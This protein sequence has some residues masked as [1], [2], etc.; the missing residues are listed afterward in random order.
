M[1]FKNKIAVIFGGSGAIGSAVA[2]ALARE[3]AEVHLAA[4]TSTRLEHVANS[5]RNAG[6][7]ASAFIFDALDEFAQL[8]EFAHIDIVVN[9]TG[10]MHDQGKRLDALALSE[11]RQGFDPF[12]T[13][14]F[15]I[16]KAVSPRMGGEHGGTLIT[17]VAPAVNMAISGH[18][19]HIVGCAGTEA[20]TRA[21]AAELGVKNIRVV[22]VRS[23]AIADAVQAG[24][25]VGAIFAAKAQEMGITVEQ[26][27]GGAAQSTLTHHLPTLAQVADTI[28]FLAS[29]AASAIT[30]TTVNMTAGAT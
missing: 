5:I 29:D 25:Y 7:S 10:F 19:G 6:G 2:H 22:C 9:A 3:G 1:G 28:T 17:V 24:S 4:R 23:H 8:P 13:A 27:L 18:L 16:A 21:L 30:G 11:F 14:Y 12:L 15:N 26:F 20:F